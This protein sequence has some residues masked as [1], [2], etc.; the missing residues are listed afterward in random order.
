MVAKGKPTSLKRPIKPQKTLDLCPWASYVLG[1]H[2]FSLPIWLEL[3]WAT[4]R[5]GSHNHNPGTL[6][7]LARELAE[8]DQ[9]IEILVNSNQITF[10]QRL[11][12]L[13]IWNKAKRLAWETLEQCDCLVPSDGFIPGYLEWHDLQWIQTELIPQSKA[14][15]RWRQLGEAVGRCQFR[16]GVQAALDEDFIPEPELETL[17]Q[18]ASA[19][20]DQGEDT[21][22][23]CIHFFVSNVRQPSP[24]KKFVVTFASIIDRS[25]MMIMLDNI[26]QRSLK[27]QQRREP[28]LVLDQDAFFFFGVRK[29][30]CQLSV[31]E[32]ACLWVLAKH[33]RIP[34]E[35][36]TIIQEGDLTCDPHN[37]RVIVSR[38][39]GTL[40]DLF[41]EAIQRGTA[42]DMILPEDCYIQGDR[43]NQHKYGP[44]RLCLDP[45]R[46]IVRCNLPT[47]RQ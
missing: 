45:D 43:P 16:L 34:L 13:R 14:L 32:M 21:T 10:T 18:Q 44:Y 11:T 25:V 19:L 26:L 22:G 6:K 31:S 17:F 9:A 15:F 28:L 33:P 29:P 40:R 41:G 46:V 47:K 37:L 27:E 24:S 3:I 42:S 23:S 2:P 39:R 4:L 35:R 1:H 7:S 12:F 38:L 30:W 20:G 5:N 36:D 8:L